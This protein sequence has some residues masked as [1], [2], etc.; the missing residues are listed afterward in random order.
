M[1]AKIVNLNLEDEDE[2]LILC[3]KDS[4]NEKDEHRLCLVGKAL[5]DCVIH[6]PSLKRTLTDLWHPLGGVI[7]SD[8]GGKWYLFQFFY[9][10]DIKRVI[11]GIPW[12]L[13]KHL[14][15]FHHLAT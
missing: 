13:N 8:L 3:K 10:V 15:V 11:N 9:E 2:E 6:F 14:V 4:S 7:I 12:S 5:T 1:E